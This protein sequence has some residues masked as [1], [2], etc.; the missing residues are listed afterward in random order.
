MRNLV[1]YTSIILS[2]W[3]CTSDKDFGGLENIGWN[4]KPLQIITRVFT[5]KSTNFVQEFTE[6]ATLGLHISSGSVEDLYNGISAYKNVRL[7]AGMEN[8]KIRWQQNPEVILDSKKATIFA[9]YPYQ[10]DININPRQIPVKLA[11]N[12]EET[13]DYMYG[14]HAIGQKA[15]SRNSPVVLLSMHHALSLLSFR[16][17]L[18]GGMTGAFI[19][20][21]VQVGNR[22]GGST[23]VSE[24]SM[25]ITTGD[26][27]GSTA[28]TIS[29]STI[30]SLVNPINLI[31]DT[32][33][34]PLEI[35]VIP[36]KGII[37][38]G[39][40]ETLFTINGGTYKFDIPADTRWE[41]GKRYIYKLS[42]NGKSLRLQDVSVRDWLPGNG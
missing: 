20:N 9:Y 25:D 30:L 32:Y 36:T 34:D 23:L 7:E 10:E 16:L 37:G 12:A 38:N 4:E 2:S 19:L 26:I 39:D 35:R 31:N 17:N 8:G 18:E 6:G 11:P 5:T 42:F 40:V 28:R 3:G 41:K 27:I 1:L 29:A 14:T 24:G 22:P 13:P 21:S 15:V 33:S